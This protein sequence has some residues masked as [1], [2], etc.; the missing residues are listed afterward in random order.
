MGLPARYTDMP[1]R[2]GEPQYS[3]LS[4]SSRSVH[5]GND[6]INGS[7]IG[8]L[9]ALKQVDDESVLNDK[10]VS[11]SAFY[12]DLYSKQA[13]KDYLCSCRC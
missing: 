10:H 11:L 4:K 1:V 12:A 5:L 8:W 13:L 9:N 2:G 7:A 6:Q 3:S